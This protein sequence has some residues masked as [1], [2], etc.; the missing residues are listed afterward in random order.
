MNALFA[1]IE[2]VKKDFPLKAFSKQFDIKDL[3]PSTLDHS[4][5]KDVSSEKDGKEGNETKE[6]RELTEEEKEFLK[7]K[8]GWTEK[9]ISK[10]TIDEDGVIHYKTDRSDMEGKTG[11]NGVPYERKRIIINGVEIEGVFPAFNSAFDAQLPEELEKSSNAKQ[12]RECNQQLKDAVNKDPELRSKFTEEQLQDIEDGYTPEG[13]VWHHNE[14]E[15]KMQ[16]VKIE[17][18]D[19]IWGGSYGNTDASYN[20]NNDVAEEK[21]EEDK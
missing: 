11:E 17:D 20:T 5:V 4:L 2:V 1:F 9:Q 7:E 16:L 21:T 18:H 19:T 15:G 12:F 3:S 14:E 13:Y 6:T 8:L 10:C